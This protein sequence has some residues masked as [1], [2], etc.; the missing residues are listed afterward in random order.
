MTYESALSLLR[1]YNSE[2]FHI[3]HAL[4]VSKVMRRMANEL[5]YGEDADTAMVY[6][7]E[8]EGA[9][10]HVYER[11]TLTLENII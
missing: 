1:Q 6:A 3:T 7:C 2:A 11:Q 5:G 8:L 4:T 9:I 10:E